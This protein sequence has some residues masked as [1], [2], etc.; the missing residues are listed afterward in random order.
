MN[1]VLMMEKARDRQ[2]R[3][4][5]LE[6]CTASL[7]LR[8]TNAPFPPD[9]MLHTLL[10]DLIKQK[11]KK[12]YKKTTIKVHFFKVDSAIYLFYV[13]G[14]VCMCVYPSYNL[15]PLSPLPSSTS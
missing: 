13:I 7:S 6:S 8:C 4:G 5:K 10:W 1:L 2:V 3:A 14:Y 11:E 12:N 9:T 15:T